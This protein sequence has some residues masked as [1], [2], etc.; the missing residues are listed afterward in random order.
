[1]IESFIADGQQAPG[2]RCT[3][4]YGQSVTDACLSWE[5][6]EPVL[7]RLAAAVRRRK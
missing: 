7:E 2:P 1:M 3:L 5:Q 4:K 6:T